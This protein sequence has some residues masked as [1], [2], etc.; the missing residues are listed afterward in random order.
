MSPLGLV[1]EAADPLYADAEFLEGLLLLRWEALLSEEAV[2]TTLVAPAVDSDGSRNSRAASAC[3]ADD[4]T[5]SPWSEWEE[6]TLG[7]EAV[8]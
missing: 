7:S 2:H 1:D 4:P 8:E 5:Q 6:P 3:T